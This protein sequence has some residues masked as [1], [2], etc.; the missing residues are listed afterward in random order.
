MIYMKYHFSLLGIVILLLMTAGCHNTDVDTPKAALS[1]SAEKP[2][3]TIVLNGIELIDEEIFVDKNHDYRYQILQIAGLRDKK[4]ETKVNNAIKA[5]TDALYEG[6]IPNYRGIKRLLPETS[7]RINEYVS[8]Y[9]S[10]NFNNFLSLIVT[11]SC[12]YNIPDSEYGQGIYQTKPLNFNLETGEQLAL[13]D[14]FRDDVDYLTVLNNKV[15]EQLARKNPVGE[16]GFDYVS[17]VY[18]EQ[19]APFQTLSENHSFSL[20]HYQMVLKLYFDETTPEFETNFST[21]SIEISL[22]ELADILSPQFWE[23]PKDIYDGVIPPTKQLVN[24]TPSPNVDLSEIDTSKENIYF[25]IYCQYNDQLP[26]K[27]I[28]KIKEQARLD[29]EL[30]TVLLAAIGEDTN[31]NG[32]YESGV[33]YQVLGRFYIISRSEYLR[34]Y[35]DGG[36]DDKWASFYDNVVYESDTLLPVNL[37]DCFVSGFDYQSKIAEVIENQLEENGLAGVYNPMDIVK[38]YENNFSLST[39]GLGL[40]ILVGEDSFNLNQVYLNIWI[41]Y[42][43][44]GEENMTIF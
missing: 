21:A 28:A 6:P 13:A 31:K 24:R 39:Q 32:I 44:L 30:K 2:W 26:E 16:T 11:R 33:H 43:E 9:D 8:V 29:E 41:P 20:D 15:K 36:E 40:D 23:T 18:M 14:L 37:K 22:F 1:A 34:V 19:V 5:H 17:G 27:V 42:R 35:S 7:V 12:Y 10:A 38:E 3:N 4:I 25:G